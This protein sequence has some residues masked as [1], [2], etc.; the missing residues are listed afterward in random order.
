MRRALALL[1]FSLPA[2]AFWLT[3]SGGLVGAWAGAQLGQ[4]VTQASAAALL[5][6]AAPA[7][8][9]ALEQVSPSATGTVAADLVQTPQSSEV[10]DQRPEQTLQPGPSATQIAT[11]DHTP[12]ETPEP[13]ETPTVL[14]ITSR[15]TAPA[16]LVPTRR[17]APVVV[18][19]TA[20]SVEDEQP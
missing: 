10:A 11:P 16:R 14:V 19:P 3:A 5:P 9:P 2:Q 1:L 15:V 6:Q 20:Q 13:P 17:P 18:V 7:P 4:L 8:T 12:T